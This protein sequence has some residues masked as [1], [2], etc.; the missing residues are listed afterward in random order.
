MAVYAASKAYVLRLTIALW[1]ELHPTGV[2][3]LAIC[4]G[5]TETEFFANA[6]NDAVMADRRTPAQ[7][8][9]TTFTALK[10]HRPYVVDGVRNTVMAFATRLAPTRLQAKLA[11]FVATH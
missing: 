2:R 9:D 10:Q 3:A 7:V 8:V 6:G 1:S 5:P 4:P 11:E